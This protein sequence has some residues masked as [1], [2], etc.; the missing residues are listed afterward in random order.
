MPLP[1]A[2]LGTLYGAVVRT[3]LRLYRSGFLKTEN[4]GAPVISVGNITAGGTGKTPLVEWVARAVAGEGR[5]VCVLTPFGGKVHAPWAMAVTATVRN[6]LQII[7]IVAE[8][9]KDN[10]R[11]GML[12]QCVNHI[13]WAL[14]ELLPAK[15]VL[16][17]TKPVFEPKDYHVKRPA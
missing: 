4:V 5:R 1:L 2:P 7:D 10:D 14:R 11:M 13:D 12:Q 9:E 17:E 16:E 3:R 8:S 15:S 6:E